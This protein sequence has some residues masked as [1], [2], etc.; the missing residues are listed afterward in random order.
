MTVGL[1]HLATM[2]GKASL[3]GMT[4]QGAAMSIAEMIPGAKPKIALSGVA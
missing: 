3:L 4:N 2:P 1:P